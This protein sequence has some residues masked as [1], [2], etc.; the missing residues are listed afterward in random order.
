MFALFCACMVVGVPPVFGVVSRLPGFSA[1]HN[2]RLL[3]Y[4]LLCW[5]CW[6]AGV[7]TISA[8]AACRARRCG[9]SGDRRR[10]SDL[11]HPDRV[12]AGPGTLN[13]SELGG[14]L[15]VAWGFVHPP[16]P[17]L[18]RPIPEASPGGVIVR[19]SALLIWLPLAGA[20]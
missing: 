6:P 3:I 8:L 1:A 10:R 15:K 2:E 18:R 12:A 20:A 11:V 19:D 17:G 7:L 4:F 13:L 5:R 14:G 16:L 9:G